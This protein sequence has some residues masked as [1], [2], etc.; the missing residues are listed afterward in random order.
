M[1]S[2]LLCGEGVID[3]TLP[4]G[5][6]ILNTRPAP[7]LADQAG[8]VERALTRPIDSPPLALL[9][10]DRKNACVVISDITRPVPNQVVL[11]PILRTLEEAGVTRDQIVI[12]IATGMHR[13][14]LGAELE[15]M[16]G[17]EIMDNYR[18]E[19]HFCR[20][21][22][23]CRQVATIDGAPI[24]INKFYLDADLKILT[25]LIEPHM[26][27]GYSGGRKS[28]LPGISSFRTMQ[29]MHSFAMIDHPKVTNCVLEG[30]PFH[31]AG[32]KV[33]EAVGADFLVN[34][35]INKDRQIVDVF[36]GRH[37]AAHQAGCKKAESLSV[38]FVEHSADLVVT[39]AGG[40]PLDATFYQ[41]SKG[42]IMAKNLVK[43]QGSVIIACE[44]REG[45]GSTE[46]C[47]MIR[48]GRSATE[49]FEHMSRPE[50][51]Q[52]DQWCL[53]T[54]YQAVDHAGKIFCYCPN[55]SQEDLANMGIVK[56][57]DVQAKIDQLAGADA[58][59]AAVPEGPYVV[60]LV[61]SPY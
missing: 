47:A 55:L 11:P 13:P 29:F 5:A 38:H 36:A 42:L 51:F 54:T 28:I 9:A 35:I 20:K 6:Q 52:I 10:A 14:N 34:V 31:E 22:E 41:V 26:Y 4:D 49:F 40:Y 24:E 44:C 50:N 59:V 25:G 1:H 57:D 21:E 23:D 32:E 27:A 61:K 17:R 43:P 8:A 53:Q 58:K 16:V 39:S 7:A 2:H 48:E 33:T 15:R 37:T 46:Y 56:I 12:L 18:I 30:N 45:L 19:N 60:G 3:I